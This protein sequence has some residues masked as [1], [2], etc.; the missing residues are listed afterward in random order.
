VA[1]GTV[2]RHRLMFPQERTAKLG[3]TARAGFRNGVLDELRRAAG[4][5]RGVAGRACHLSFQQ[6]MMRWLRKIGVLRLVAGRARLDLRRGIVH[7]VFGIVQRMTTRAGHIARRVRARG[8]FVRGVGLM[9]TQALR[10]LYGCRSCGLCTEVEHA[11]ERTASG[12]HMPAARAV[13][14]FALQLPVPKGTM[15]IIRACVLGSKNL[16]DRGIAMAAEAG[17]GALIAVIRLRLRW[18]IRRMRVHSNAEEEQ[19]RG[20]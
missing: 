13:T 15:R 16:R 19:R 10:I 5:M 17:I 8:P 2:L 11:G 18:S 20:G 14:C 7:R 4:A 3:M 6:R 12:L 1:I 9:A